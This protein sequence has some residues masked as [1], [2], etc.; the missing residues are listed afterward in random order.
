M[1]TRLSP[2]FI[3]FLESTS[4]T[5]YVGVVVTLIQ[6]L[7]ERNAP[8]N[9]PLGGMMMLM[10]FVL[11]ALISASIM[12]GYPLMLWRDKKTTQAL[13]IVG[14]S[15]AWLA[16]FVAVILTVGFMV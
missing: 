2:P 1:N 11:S 16:L 3:G 10:L 6:T 8:I 5:L 12:L 4:L 7:G 13:V 9:P 15:I 14:S